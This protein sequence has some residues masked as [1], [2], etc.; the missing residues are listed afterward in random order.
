MIQLLPAESGRDI[1]K[2]V[3]DSQEV[4]SSAMDIQMS[5]VNKGDVTRTMRFQTLVQN[6]NGLTKTITLFLEPASV[7]NTRF[8]TIE[9]EKR[10]E[11]QWIYLPALKKVKRIAVSERGGSF[12]GS[13]FSY[14]DMSLLGATSLD[15]SV[16]TLLREESFMG[17]DCYV[18]ESVTKSS[19][20]SVY[21]KKIIWV[22]KAGWYTVKVEFFSAKGNTKVKEL[23]SEDFNVIQDRWTA[24]KTTMNTLDSGH[25]TVLDL[26][27]V[28]YD[29][30]IK[31]SFFTTT[32]LETG[33]VR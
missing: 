12:M 20:D 29:I 8:L 6:D 33:R 31:P 30:P 1:I 21:G 15:D 25:S 22:D 13:D 27:Q 14:A 18:V 23:I 5:L 2:R 4:S 9:N 28:K 7:K 10:N 17:H 32:F 16:H 11:D 26:V 24:G 19:A 3:I